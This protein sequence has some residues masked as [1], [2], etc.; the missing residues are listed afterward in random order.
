VVST[1]TI[2]DDP[3]SV[4]LSD[5]GTGLRVVADINS[6]HTQFSNTSSSEVKLVIRAGF[7]TTDAATYLDTLAP[8]G[9]VVHVEDAVGTTYFD[10]TA[11]NHATNK[12]IHV[13]CLN[14]D[15][16]SEHERWACV[17]TRTP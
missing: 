14:W 8:G 7:N 16:P 3:N 11:F 5:P 1:S 17:G 15:V 13:D 6:V 9:S 10:V 2:A 4:I 12:S